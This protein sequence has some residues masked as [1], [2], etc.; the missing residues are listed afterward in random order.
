MPRDR[1]AAAVLAFRS[2]PQRVNRVS[3][4]G[5]LTD[6]QR[7]RLRLHESPSVTQPAV[8]AALTSDSPA[9]CPRSDAMALQVHASMTSLRHWVPSSA[10]HQ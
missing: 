3:V 8:S 4:S 5:E 7:S 6:D 10:I 1:L 2:S 9:A